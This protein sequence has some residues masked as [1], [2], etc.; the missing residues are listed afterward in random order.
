MVRKY[1]TRLIN[2]HLRL[3]DFTTV[4]ITSDNDTIISMIKIHYLFLFRLTNFL[5]FNHD[6]ESIKLIYFVGTICL[7]Y[8]AM[9]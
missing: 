9:R 7:L 8:N 1:D 4:L 2:I 5:R 3:S 6:P